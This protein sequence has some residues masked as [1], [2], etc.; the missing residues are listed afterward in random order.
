MTTGVTIRSRDGLSLEGAV[1]EPAGDAMA[2]LVLCH[3]HPQMGGTMNAPLLLMLRDALVTQGWRVIR[4]NFRG[5]GGSEG[6]TGIGDDEVH[7]A[8]GALDIARD[9]GLP[10]AIAGWSFGAAIAVR[11]AAEEETI[12]CVAIAPPITAREGVTAGV[13]EAIP[14]VPTLVVVGANDVQVD[15]A[16]CRRWAESAGL[17]FVELRGANHFFWAKYDDLAEVVTKFLAEVA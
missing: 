8:G 7:D 12:A 11:V 3:P 9:A 10:V 16:E 14:R 1:N 17:A 4:F 6:T 5:I 2:T 13:R 15:P